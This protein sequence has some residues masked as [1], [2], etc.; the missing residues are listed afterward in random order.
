LENDHILLYENGSIQVI[1]R[2]GRE[3]FTIKGTFYGEPIQTLVNQQNVFGLAKSN[4]LLFYHTETGKQQKRI[5]FSETIEQWKGMLING[6]HGVGIKTGNQ[7]LYLDISNGK[8]YKFNGNPQDFVGFTSSGA[9]FRG[10]KGMELHGL[11]QSLEVQVPSYWKFGGELTLDG[12]NGTLF[13]DN[14]TVVFAIQGKIRWK[15]TTPLSEISDVHTGSGLVVLR[16]DL[17]NKLILLNPNGSIF[18][19]EERP[20]QGELQSTPFG[21]SGCSITTLLNGYLIQYNF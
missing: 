14:K 3:L 11:K 21:S 9:I 1:D 12:Q 19:Q 4:E 7:V 20:S 10:K 5:S 16:D 13:Y 2:M 17:Q 18:D 15:T 6:K 8:K